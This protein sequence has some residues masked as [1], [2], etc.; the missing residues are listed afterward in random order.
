MDNKVAIVTG[1][2]S[3]IGQSIVLG[4]AG[5][6]Y[7]VYASTRN[8]SSPSSSEL[9]NLSKKNILDV[10]LISL[11]LS[12]P[13]SVKTAISEIIKE[14]GR[15]DVLVNNAASGY[16]A[17]VEDIE[18][19]EF[20]HQIQVNVLGAIL[21]AQAVLPQ[22]R[23]QKSGKIINIS[24][25][26]GFSTAPLNAPYSASKYALESISE[27]LALEVKPFG[28]DVAILQLGDFHSKFLQNSTRPKY[29]ADSPYYKLYKRQDEKI[30]IGGGRGKNPAIIARTIAKICS[31]RTSALRYMIGKE[32]FIRKSLH[33]V[34]IDNLW[35]KFLR[36][37]Y[38]W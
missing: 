19:A 28:I 38:K 23:K 10:R 29:T 37:F 5:T 31:E 7:R 13:D 6:G 21:T 26:M 3:G 34:L 4:L 35:I 12:K 20:L 33:T 24:S 18:V 11:D 22:M 14:S 36:F 16:F 8:I 15:V 1:G 17:A 32:V 9:T 27:T 30:N 2:V 25:I